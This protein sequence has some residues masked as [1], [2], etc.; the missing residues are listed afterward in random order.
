MIVPCDIY[1]VGRS[2][3]PIE[4]VSPGDRVYRLGAKGPEIGRV[5]SISSHM[6][7][8]RI[9]VVRT[10]MQQIDATN[11][12][13]YLYT[14]ETHGQKLIAFNQIDRLTPNKEYIPGKYLPVLS[15]PF[16]TST[17]ECSDQ[18]I[19][20]LAR[21][22]AVERIAYNQE[23]FLSIS[24][25]MTGDDAFVFVDLLEHWTSEHPGVGMFGK[26]NRK[27]RAFFFKSKTLCD[28][29]SRLAC[30]AGYCTMLTGYEG[31]YVQQIFFDGVAIPGNTPKNEKYMRKQYF[32]NVYNLNSDNRPV[33]GR[34]GARAYYLPCTSTMNEEYNIDKG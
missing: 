20:F 17:R 23:K 14:S 21:M 34:F 32:G 30:L 3:I 31:G 16:F 12:T 27:S 11:D 22:L 24:Q 7:N 33:F 19:E 26:L 9:D 6:I 25:R 10:G 18:E 4:C 5:N 2:F 13:R 29:I 15:M 1:V 8:A 28:E